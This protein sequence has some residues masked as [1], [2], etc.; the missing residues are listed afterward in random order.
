MHPM[1]APAHG[2][3]HREMK[4]CMNFPAALPRQLHRLLSRGCKGHRC[5]AMLLLRGSRPSCWKGNLR[6]GYFL[7]K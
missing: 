1:Y 4:M 3:V 2:H 5:H 7:Q 6:R